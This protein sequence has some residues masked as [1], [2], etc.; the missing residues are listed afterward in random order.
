[1]GFAPMQE[2]QEATMN[3]I[4]LKYIEN[5]EKDIIPYFNEDG[6]LKGIAIKGVTKTPM[7]FQIKYFSEEA[8][9]WLLKK[10]EEDHYMNFKNPFIKQTEIQKSQQD[11]SKRIKSSKHHLGIEDELLNMRSLI[12]VTDG[13]EGVERFDKRL[14]EAFPRMQQ[15]LMG[16]SESL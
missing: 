2:T 3:K 10:Y 16:E 9:Y 8:K 7:F 6:S 15:Y 11:F 5:K 14:E 13:I 4:L 1:M 12:Y